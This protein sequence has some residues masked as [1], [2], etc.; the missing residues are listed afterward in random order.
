[1]L[2]NAVIKVVFLTFYNVFMIH[3]YMDSFLIYYSKKRM[4]LGWMPFVLWEFIRITSVWNLYPEGILTR[5]NPGM[6]LCM[7]IAVM[8]IA[9]LFAYQGELWKRLLFPMMYVALLMVVEAAVVFGLNYVENP[10]FSMIFYLILS[11]SLMSVLIVGIRNYVKV[12][13]IHQGYVKDGK[14]LL[15]L[16]LMGMNLYYVLYRMA[17]LIKPENKDITRGLIMSAILLLI[18]LLYGYCIYGRMAKEFQISENNR[19]YVHQLGVYKNYFQMR[20]EAA[21]EI[22]RIKHDLK[23]S[24]LLIEHMLIQH[25]YEEAQTMVSSMRGKLCSPHSLRN[26]T[27]NLALDAQINQMWETAEEKGIKVKSN[28]DVQKSLNIADED[29]SVILGNA[30]DNAF[31][32][33]AKIPDQ[34]QQLWM[35]VKYIKGILFIQVKNTYFG[36]QF[37]GIPKSSKTKKYHGIGLTSMERMVKKYR[38]KMKIKTEDNWFSLEIVL[39][40]NEQ[41]IEPQLNNI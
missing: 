34:E 8:V 41:R 24:F 40:E 10:D 16:P 25:K 1:M 22:L 3:L 2:E 39:Y 23:Q 27:G 38:G 19:F 31:E 12:K 11:N 37:M 14:S 17:L 30:I 20:K 15:I 35:E 4:L 33:L 6:N 26:C 29:L 36:E 13:Q 32:A 5:Q 28:I 7:N 9:G 18:I 21:Q